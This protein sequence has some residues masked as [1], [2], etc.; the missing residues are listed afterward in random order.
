[1]SSNQDETLLNQLVGKKEEGNKTQDKSKRFK[2][3]NKTTYFVSR[4]INLNV[5]SFQPVSFCWFNLGTQ[6]FV[7]KFQ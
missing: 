4:Y 7:I 6:T 1:M 2:S 3:T 5:E